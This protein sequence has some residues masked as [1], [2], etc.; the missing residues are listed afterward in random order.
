MYPGAVHPHAKLDHRDDSS[1]LLLLYFLRLKLTI[2]KTDHLPKYLVLLHNIQGV[3]RVARPHTVAQWNE[4]TVC[5]HAW[6][7]SLRNF[8]RIDKRA[9][10]V[11][12]I[13]KL[14][15]VP[16]PKFT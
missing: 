1:S 3:F 4:I 10:W 15:L 16:R 11:I 8:T 2:F 5:R 12:L 6:C 14:D 7:M 13:Q 9:F